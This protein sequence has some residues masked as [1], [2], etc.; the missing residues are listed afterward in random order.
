MYGGG[1]ERG[2]TVSVYSHLSNTVEA[3]LWFAVDF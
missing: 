3:P 1:Q 2:K